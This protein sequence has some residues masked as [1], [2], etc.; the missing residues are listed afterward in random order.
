MGEMLLI[1]MVGDVTV[2]VRPL[3]TALPTAT[4]TFPVIAVGGTVA[5]IVVLLHVVALA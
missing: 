1:F 3:L 5:T 4:T 2:K